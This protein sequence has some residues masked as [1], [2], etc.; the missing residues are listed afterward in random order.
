MDSKSVISL[1]NASIFQRD[2]CVLKNVNFDIEEGEFVY[3][4]G[5][6]GSGKSSLLKTL[7]ADLPAKEGELSI[8]DYNLRTIKKRDI[9]MLR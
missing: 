2:R 5:K 3:L 1:K 4:I 8:A 9:P 6:T 7:Y